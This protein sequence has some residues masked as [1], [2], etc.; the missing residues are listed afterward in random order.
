MSKGSQTQ[1][2][3][4]YIIHLYEVQKQV[5]L[6]ELEVKLVTSGRDEGTSMDGEVVQGSLQGFASV[7]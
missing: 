1:R 3:R 6:N 7:L 2:S 4:Y 5:K